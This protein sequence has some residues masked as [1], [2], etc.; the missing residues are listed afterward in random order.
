MSLLLYTFQSDFNKVSRIGFKTTPS[1][2]RFATDYARD[3][4]VRWGKSNLAQDGRGKEVDF[5]HCLN[6]AR[7]IK[8]N[9]Q[10][11]KA[12]MQL[13]QVVPTPRI[14]T[15][16]VS[17]RGLVVVRPFNHGGGEDFKVVRGPCKLPRGF[18]ATEYIKTNTELRCWF[19]RTG[20]DKGFTMA[21][22]RVKMKK[23]IEGIHPCRSQWGYHWCK[24]PKG[25]HLMT[26]KAA[27]KIGL[28]IGACDILI[29]RGRPVFLETNSAPAVDAKRIREFFLRRI[30]EAAAAK[31][32]F[33]RDAMPV[34]A[35]AALLGVGVG[36]FLGRRPAPAPDRAAEVAPL[37]R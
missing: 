28:D 16:R 24:A 8:L 15:G 27:T 26:L 18:Y 22:R 1:M 9:T 17:L 20:P 14:W 13:S 31:F 23:D 6:P 32:P 10:K 5:M 21:A 12:L 2:G 33:I 11:A 34:A 19:V 3:I 37:R 29:K 4:I 36:G 25:L 7:A 30:P 35:E